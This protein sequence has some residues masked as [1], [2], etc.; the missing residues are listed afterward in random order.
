M[1][2]VSLSTNCNISKDKSQTY[3]LLIVNQSSYHKWIETVLPFQYAAPNEANISLQ[4]T[5]VRL[6]L[7][8]FKVL[9]FFW[10]F[11]FHFS[12]RVQRAAKASQLQNRVFSD[13]LQKHD[14]LRLKREEETDWLSFY[15]GANE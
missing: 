1:G 2:Q 15:S 12:L 6:A 4:H 11:Y 7:F 10:I 8:L 9:R 3:R 5:A 13:E 14:Y